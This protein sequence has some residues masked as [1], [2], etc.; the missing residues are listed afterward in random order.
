MTYEQ[1][2]Q[3]VKLLQEMNRLAVPLR[4]VEALRKIVD[5]LLYILLDVLEA[6]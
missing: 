6:E 4:D 3:L 2:E 1:K 5:R